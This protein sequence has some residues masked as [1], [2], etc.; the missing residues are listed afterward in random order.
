MKSAFPI[1]LAAVLLGAITRMAAAADWLTG[2]TL[3]TQLAQP[4]SVYWE[5]AAL[6]ETLEQFS[7]ARR[8]AVFID[9]RIDPG[10]KIDLR[11][12]AVPVAEVFRQVADHCSAGLTPFG[13]VEY[14]GP[15]EFAA[16]LR[17]LAALRH[18]DARRL[19]PIVAERLLR[20]RPWKWND[21]ATPRE[22][23][24]ILADEGRFEIVGLDRVPHDLW[25][26][27]D[28]PP[29]PLVD[30]V[31]LVL[32]Q[33]DL[34]FTLSDDGRRVT[35]VPIP[36]DV[37]IVR[38]YSV[39]SLKDKTAAQDAQSL[40]A[41]LSAL[42]PG[43]QFRLADGKVYAKGRL[44][45]IEQIDG[46]RRPTTAAPVASTKPADGAA[47]RFTGR[48]VNKPLGEVLRNIGAQFGFELAIDRERLAHAGVSLDQFV[49]F[50]V[51]NAT[52]D[53]LLAAVL[54]PVGCTFRR[55]GQTIEIE[56]AK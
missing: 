39:A 38:S 43:C 53:E 40:L 47:A 27:A 33:F 42:A 26:A 4:T 44:E 49:S 30:R 29:L 35:L 22:L 11:A 9:R 1:V 19:P 17:T 13:P 34:T 52:A 45:E 37:A 31:T 16:K 56:P 50:S 8:V 21:L 51:K 41:E 7:R 6:R 54:E 24:T 5:D 23:L 3:Q 46:T 32:G 10:Q 15:S 36:H 48:V 20:P 28:L 18:E 2:G 14:L 25:A 12:Q 55:R